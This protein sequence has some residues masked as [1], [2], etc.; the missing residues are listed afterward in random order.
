MFTVT[1]AA[2]E[3]ILES[4]KQGDAD[5]SNPTLRIAAKSA[6]DGS[7]EY[8][9]GFD[10]A[11]DTDIRVKSNGVTIIFDPSQQILLEGATM[12]YIEMDPGQFNFV[13]LNIHS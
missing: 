10:D 1:K 2:A 9:L 11:A 5:S 6:A 4:A 3:Q 8:L 7:I 13:F 12:D